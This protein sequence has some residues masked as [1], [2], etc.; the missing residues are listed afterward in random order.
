MTSLAPP[1]FVSLDSSE[2]QESPCLA[3]KFTI[4]SCWFEIKQKFFFRVK[5]K[6][7]F[8]RLI[9]VCEKTIKTFCNHFLWGQGFSAWFPNGALSFSSSV[10]CHLPSFFPLFRPAHS[11]QILACVMFRGQVTTVGSFRPSSLLRQG[12]SC[13]SCTAC[14]RPARSSPVRP[15]PAHQSPARPSPVHQSP[16]H[17]SPA[18]PRPVYPRQAGP[19][20]SRASLII[21]SHLA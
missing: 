5:A 17:Q 14:P 4:S 21:T 7:S 16:A 1:K 2:D 10:L 11:M 18:R 12:L 15:S 19:E 9:R 20:L 6:I 8:S 3:K 13:F